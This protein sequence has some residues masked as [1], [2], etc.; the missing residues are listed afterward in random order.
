MGG[1]YNTKG[2]IRNADKTFVEKSK[3]KE[4]L[5]RPRRRRILK[6]NLRK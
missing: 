2:D 3:G 4:P 6:Y 5:G 1:A